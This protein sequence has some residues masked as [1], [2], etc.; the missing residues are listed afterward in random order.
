MMLI[1]IPEQPIIQDW[2]PQKQNLIIIDYDSQLGSD[3]E[4]QLNDISKRSQ[5]G[6]NLTEMNP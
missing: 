6:V 2:I 5:D 3:T 4:I 1:Y